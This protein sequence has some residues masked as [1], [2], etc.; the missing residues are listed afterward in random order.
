MSFEIGAIYEYE[1]RI[2]LAVSPTRIFSLYNNKLVFHTQY[3]NWFFYKVI[4]EDFKF[5]TKEWGVKSKDI[6]RVTNEELDIPEPRTET[7]D[8]DRII[9]KLFKDH[10]KTL[11]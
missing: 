5:L 11:R 1:K 7:P 8:Y 3:T 10:T 6:D 4:K 9:I 2:Y